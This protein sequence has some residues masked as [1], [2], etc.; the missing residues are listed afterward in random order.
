MLIKWN[1]RA[2]CRILIPDISSVLRTHV[3]RKANAPCIVH[4]CNAIFMYSI[5]S[6]V[7]AA[8]GEL[9]ELKNCLG[10]HESLD[11][12]SIKLCVEYE[13]QFR[14]DSPGGGFD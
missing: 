5:D 4:G 12:L 9:R 6:T 10:F 1:E 13:S 11:N 3:K 2:E 14:R 7:V 8:I